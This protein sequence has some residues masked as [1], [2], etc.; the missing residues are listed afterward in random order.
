MAQIKVVKH[1]EVFAALETLNEIKAEIK[2]S[3][4]GDIFQSCHASELVVTDVELCQILQR[5]QIFYLRNPVVAEIN[6]GDLFLA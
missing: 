5:Y 3:E 2:H 4:V 1:A 6:F